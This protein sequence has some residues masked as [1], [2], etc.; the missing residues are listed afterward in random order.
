M[1][2][3]KY[4]LNKVRLSVLKHRENIHVFN[5]IFVQFKLCRFEYFAYYYIGK[6]SSLLSL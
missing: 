1:N 4:N 6:L 5:N 2:L 3:K